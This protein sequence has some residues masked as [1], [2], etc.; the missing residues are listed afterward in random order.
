MAPSAYLASYKGVPRKVDER[1]LQSMAEFVW[2]S[3]G[4]SLVGRSDSVSGAPGGWFFAP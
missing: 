2:R 1:C 3:V 4:R